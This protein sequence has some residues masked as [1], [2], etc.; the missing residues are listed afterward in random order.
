[1]FPGLCRAHCFGPQGEGGP[2]GVT[3]LELSAHSL[4]QLEKGNG[5]EECHMVFTKYTL[6]ED[7][8]KEKGAGERH[9]VFTERPLP[10]TVLKVP[11]TGART[12]GV[13]TEDDTRV[14]SLEEDQ[15][16]NPPLMT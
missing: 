5:P 13:D 16:L 4:G 11:N 8:R 10:E 1:M 3:K 9:R 6:T 7:N 15:E 12:S 2:E 14:L